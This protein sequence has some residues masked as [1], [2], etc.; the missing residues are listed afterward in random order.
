MKLSLLAP[1]SLLALLPMGCDSENDSAE[2][3]VTDAPAPGDETPAP[4]ADASGQ[5]IDAVV[6]GDAAVVQADAAPPAGRCVAPL[7]SLSTGPD[8]A[9]G[10]GGVHTFPLGLAPADCHGWRAVDPMG[11]AHDNS[12]NAIGCNAD[13]SFSFT[14]FA[15]SIDCTGNGAVKSYVLDECEQD[16]PPSLYSVATNLTCCSEP[17]SEACVVGAPSVSQAGATIYLDGVLCED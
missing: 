2:G 17:D 9:C 11:E 16:V 3:Q 8:S 13:G 10:G 12:A 1:F 15:G 4:E 5:G 7:A 6:Q 14:Q